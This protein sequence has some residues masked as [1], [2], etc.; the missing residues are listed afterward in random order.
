MFGRIKK[1]KIL[2]YEHSIQ[3]DPVKMMKIFRIIAACMN[4]FGSD[5]YSAPNIQTIK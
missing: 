2:R 3:F 5:L 1:W 4:D